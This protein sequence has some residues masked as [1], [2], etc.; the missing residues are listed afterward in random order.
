MYQ[1]PILEFLQVQKIEG[2]H[3]ESEK[4]DLGL[5]IRRKKI[6]DFFSK[7]QIQIFRPVPDD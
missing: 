1:N 3:P 7:V 4:L 2:T 6:V 5:L